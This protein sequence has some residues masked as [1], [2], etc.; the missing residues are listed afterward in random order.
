MEELLNRGREA[1]S[2]G[3][4]EEAKRLLEEALT[5]EESPEVLEGLSW[6]CWW[7]NDAPAVFENRLKAYNLFLNKNDKR[8]A[9]RMAS[10]IGI[11]YL[12]F[13]GELA[14]ANG[15]FQR[16]EN[17]LEG[18]EDTP[19]LGLIKLLKGR[20]AFMVDKN[21]ELALKLTEESLQLSRSLNN[22]EGEMI[23]EAFKG[24]ILVTEGKISE[25]M[26]L[27]DEATVLALTA[28]TSDINMITNTC[29]FLIDACER[30]RDYER[31]GQ[32]CIKVKEICER[33]RHRAMFASCRTQYASVLIWRGDWN[34]AEEELLSAA[35]ELKEYRPVQVN[36]S[37]VRL[38]DLR[39]RQGKWDEAGKLFDEVQSDSLKPLGCAALAFDKGDYETA[40]NLAERFL[41]QIPYKEK[42]ERITGLEL[43]L[44]IYIKLGR[45]EEAE[46]LLI[47]LKEIE[48]AICTLPLKAASLSAEGIFNY[49]LG[50]YEL[51][52]QNLEDAIDIYDKITS[53]FESS[54]T[55]LILSEV[56]IKIEQYSQTE[57]EL[58]TA[59]KIFKK[60]GAEKDF[61][62]AKYLLKNLH[63]DSVELEANGNKYEF[64]GR[65]LE[66]LRLITEGKNNEEIAEKFF[67]SVRT[68]EK[69]ITNI[70]QKLGISGKS[71][72]AFAASYAIKNNLILT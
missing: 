63:K 69:H 38:A 23:A 32:W 21:T 72:R 27:L 53:P 33:W 19:E 59:M 28:Q 48:K 55:R 60:L 16:A 57:S 22:V 5:T 68:V 18:L 50:N 7:L 37:I 29:C 34:E 11:D 42:T 44:R 46:T 4:W 14:V 71:A 58:N 15:W 61:E 25:G 64:T 3:E 36:S 31:A 43:L 1:L 40:L 13:K 56:L 41:R 30:V 35:K 54:R 62:K 6:A 66:V 65:E 12:E 51:A 10:W 47:E 26:S 24:F 39:R 9:S 45:L 8:G 52:K 70:Y 49:A 2:V 67:L 17:L 20:L